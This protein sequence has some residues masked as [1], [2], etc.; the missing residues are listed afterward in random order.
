MRADTSTAPALG[1]LA[2]PSA[3]HRI[4]AVAVGL[5]AAALLVVGASGSVKVLAVVIGA[6]GATSALTVA[7]YVPGLPER[8]WLL[9]L[10]VTLSISLKFHLVSDPDHLGG[11]IGFRVAASDMALGALA[12]MALVRAFQRGHVRLAID[13]ALLIASVI[14]LAAAIASTLGSETPSLGWFELSALAQAFALG[15]FLASRRWSRSG[16]RV[17]LNGLM[18]ALL[19]QSSVA[20]TQV[21]RP[22]L[23]NLEF[24]GAAQYRETPAGALPAID[25]GTTT[26]GGQTTYRP[27]GLLIHPNLF[28][29][30]LVLTLP[31][32]L[33]LALASPARSDR[34]LAILAAV[35]AAGALY[36]SL[37][38]SGWIGFA[39]AFGLGGFMAWRSDAVR[40]TARH[41]LALAA[42]GLA[43]VLGVGWKAPRIYQRFTETATAAIEF[44]RD[45]ALAAW[46]M[47]LDH[48][49]LG[50]GLNTF[51]SHVTRYDPT[52]T[53]RLKAFPVHNAFLLE[54]SETGFAGGL[55]FAAMALTML[56]AAGRAARRAP[57]ETHLIAIALAAGIAGFWV[58]QLSD[59]FYRIPVITSLVWAHA[60]LTIGIARGEARQ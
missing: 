37:S 16:R 24:L 45:Y 51:T 33:A 46:R 52:G 23:V 22:G 29:A 6:L 47:A 30:Y 59:Y 49:A 60:G 35:M 58:T 34:R 36:L 50:V 4:A 43:V 38:R 27:T 2:G 3:A 54:L 14:Y 11:A 55:A 12:L 41:R 25:I 5:M 26:M 17:F 32:A 44:R 18:I 7:A 19:L 48:P 10:A 13:P 9:T 39:V 1:P 21:W 40:L 28:A 42:V 15:L 31:L 8:L 56:I 53:A 57:I 20:V